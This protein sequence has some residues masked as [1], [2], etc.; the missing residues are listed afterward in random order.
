MYIQYI[1]IC[2]SF[3]YTYTYLIVFVSM[4][5]CMFIVCIICFSVHHVK[6]GC[7]CKGDRFHTVSLATDYFGRVWQ[8][9]S[10]KTTVHDPEYLPRALPTAEERY[11]INTKT[12]WT[13]HGSKSCFY[14]QLP[15]KHNPIFGPILETPLRGSIP[16]GGS[17]RFQGAGL[18][19]LWALR[20]GAAPV[21]VGSCGC[22]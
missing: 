8:H 22:L 12:Q 19:L 17:K 15:N 13:S 1:Y 4:S 16:A 20:L 18:G 5:M 7:T 6:M 3:V 10:V 2:E 11:K 9:C 21:R 14:S